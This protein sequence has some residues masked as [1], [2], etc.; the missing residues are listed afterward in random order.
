MPT[1]NQIKVLM[2]KPYI[3]CYAARATDRLDDGGGHAVFAHTRR[4]KRRVISQ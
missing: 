2:M 3:H 1:R 4:L